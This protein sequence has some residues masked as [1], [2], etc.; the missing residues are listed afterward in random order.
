M[1]NQ[2]IDLEV[3]PRIQTAREGQREQSHKHS[4]SVMSWGFIFMDYSRYTLNKLNWLIPQ[5]LGTTFP[6]DYKVG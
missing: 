5:N 1:Q 2:P 4:P 6:A 3:L